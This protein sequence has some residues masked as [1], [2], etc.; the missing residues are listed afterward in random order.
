METERS[1]WKLLLSDPAEN[2]WPRIR[3]S[4]SMSCLYLQRL[5]LS[6]CSSWWFM[7][8][9][10]IPKRKEFLIV[11]FFSLKLMQMF[12][13]N[14]KRTLCTRKH[15]SASPGLYK[16]SC[17]FPLCK[18][19]LSTCWVWSKTL[20]VMVIWWFVLAAWASHIIPHMKL[21]R[22]LAGPFF[23]HLYFFQ[24]QDS[25]GFNF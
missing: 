22:T 2:S 18:T 12:I 3:L 6:F 21:T 20:A 1:Q 4:Y 23:R 10:F 16:Y 8:Q 5:Y 15:P 9:T 19:S 25:H 11:T 17:L 7:T 24:G 14:Y 13:Y